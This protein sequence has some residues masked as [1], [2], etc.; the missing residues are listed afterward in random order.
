M[1]LVHL[2]A[3]ATL[4]SG[5]ILLQSCCEK[6]KTE[7]EKPVVENHAG[8]YLH[9]AVLWYQLSG[10]MQA[11][12]YQAF[13]LAKTALVANVKA[14]KSPLK[15]AV[16]LDI[17]ETLLDNSP[18][19]AEMSINHNEF[20]PEL[21]EEWSKMEKAVALPGAVDFIRFALENNVEV[22]YVSNRLDS[23]LQWTLNNM[24]ALGFPEIPAER[25]YLKTT[26]SD[27]KMRRDSIMQNYSVVL[28]IGDN[29]A[30]FSNDFDDRKTD[31][32]KGAV[33]A[34]AALFGTRYVIIPN[35]TYGGWEKPLYDKSETPKFEQRR[36][37]M[38]SYEDLK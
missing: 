8:D 3:V 6:P 4:V 12:S 26:T 22:F 37:L 16:I 10:E 27:K 25:F 28:F 30:D 15:K 23:E 31:Y 29:L 36:K 19:M 13:N 1:K 18:F 5:S 17:D 24:K 14:D 21:W 9:Q 2:L 32:A 38:I 33:D 20:S 11:C 7:S 35:P 34:N